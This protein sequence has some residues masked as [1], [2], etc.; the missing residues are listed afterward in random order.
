MRFIFVILALLCGIALLLKIATGT[1]DA[2]QVAGLGII[3]LC[4]AVVSPVAWPTWST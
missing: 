1:L 2:N 3:F 4:L